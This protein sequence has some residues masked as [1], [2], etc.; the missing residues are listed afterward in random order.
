ML[1]VMHA[2]QGIAMTI[3]QEAPKR[4]KVESDVRDQLQ[5]TTKQ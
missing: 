1:P 2:T 5:G 4:F 3:N